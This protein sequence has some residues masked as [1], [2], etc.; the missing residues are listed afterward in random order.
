MNPFEIEAREVAKKHEM[1]EYGPVVKLIGL[2]YTW[3]ASIVRGF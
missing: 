3:L 2:K 1:E